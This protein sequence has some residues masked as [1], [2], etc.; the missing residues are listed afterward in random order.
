MNNRQKVFVIS[1]ALIFIICIIYRYYTLNYSNEGIL[2]NVTSRDGYSLTL[3]QE[4]VPI[5]VYIKPDWI[6]FNPDD[7]KELNIK[8]LEMHNTNINLD[9]VLNRGNDIYFSFH[10]TFNMK[11]NNGEFLYNGLFNEDGSFS[12]PTGEIIVYDK[13]RNKIPIGQIG[14]GPGADFS[15]GIQ[16]QDQK[17]IQNGFYVRYTGYILYDY[18]K[19]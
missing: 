18:S 13:D 7:G 5:E 1:L 3:K 16:P 9:N 12:S 19:K 15:F 8:L 6:S 11:Y 2:N 14:Y 17:L 10:S 4:Q